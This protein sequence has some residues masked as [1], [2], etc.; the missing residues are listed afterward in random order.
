MS[1]H[2][3]KTRALLAARLRAHVPRRRRDALLLATWNLREFDTPGY[4]ERTDECLR[5][6]ADIVSRFE[7]VAIQE[8][9]QDLLALRRL[10]RMLG[11]HWEFLV[12]DVSE[13]DVGN[14]ERL[15]FVYDTRSVRFGGL[16]GEVVLP[17]AKRQFARTPYTCAFDVCGTSIQLCTVHVYYGAARAVDTRRLAEIRA[18]AQTLAARAAE[19]HAWT[20]NLCL[21]GDFNISRRTDVTYE[22]ITEAGFEIPGALQNLPGSNVPKNKLYDQM[23]LL[24]GGTLQCSERARVFDFYETVYRAEDEGLYVRDMGEPYMKSKNPMQYYR[25]KWRTFQMSDHL[26][27]WMQLRTMR[28]PAGRLSPR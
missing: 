21:L 24:P 26:P 9:R 6:I 2:I 18:V 20:P 15:A 12:T 22:A 10:L 28:A 11:P 7:I 4:G 13:G 3:D 23:A 16:A 1:S 25:S 27:M 8:V 14:N 19:K 5:Y 17:G